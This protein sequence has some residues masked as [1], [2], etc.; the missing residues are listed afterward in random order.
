M[1]ATPAEAVPP[2]RPVWSWDSGGGAW[3]P[4]DAPTSRKLEDA[5]LR[6]DPQCDVGG[7]RHIDLA[8]RTKLRQRVTAA[9]Q[10]SRKVRRQVL[11]SA[12]GSLTAGGEPEPEPDATTAA[13][14]P[15]IT[16]AAR[17]S[18]TRIVG[19]RE[20]ACVAEVEAAICTAVTW[21]AAQS[22]EASAA[23]APARRSTRRSFGNLDSA[24]RDASS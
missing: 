3:A 23:C 4:Y 13:A 2:Q 12:D 9:P 19:G 5:F 14:R 22:R 21:A 15:P 8:D 16:H 10:R 18:G 1:A 7:G 11:D 20:H 6:G 24:V 17:R